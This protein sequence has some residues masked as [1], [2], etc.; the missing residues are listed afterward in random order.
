MSTENYTEVTTEVSCMPVSTLIAL[1]TWPS[2]L[3]LE[4]GRRLTLGE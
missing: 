3:P 4:E 2:Q 1:V